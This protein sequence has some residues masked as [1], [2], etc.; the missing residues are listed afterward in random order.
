VSTHSC[1]LAPHLK[2][3]LAAIPDGKYGRMFI[4]LPI[5]VADEAA[6]LALGR[7]H[8]VIDSAIEPETGGG[9]SDN[10]R[11]PAGF[12]IFGQFVA[13]DITADRSLLQ[14]HA[15]LDEL[16]NFRAPRLDLESVYAA[17]PVGSPYLYDDNDPDK[18]LIGITDAGQPDDLPRNQQGIAL[19]GDPRNDVHLIIS[20]MHLAFLKFH[21]RI[22]DMLRSQGLDSAAVF[23]TARQLVRWHYQWIVIHEFLPLNVGAEVVGDILANGRQFYAYVERPFIPIEFA[24]AAYRFGHSQI[25]AIYRLNDHAEGRIFPD[26]VGRQPVPQDRAIDW[27]CIFS[28][29]PDRPPQLSKLIDGRMVH[30]LID[31]PDAIVGATAN[32]DERSLACR[33]LQRG[34]SLD[35]P[36]GEAVSRAMGIEP[37]T[38]AEC[39]LADPALLGETP[40]WL[41]ILKEA[42]VRK[43]GETL[44]NVGGRIVVEV[45]IGL[46]EGDADSYLNAA[47]AWRPTLPSA[48]PGNFTMADLLR[49]AGVA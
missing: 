8:A 47:I 14:H 39:G 44:G 33:D 13:H 12:P 46:I 2:D 36:S 40:L 32:R 22:V 48:Q 30:P 43:R 1:V 23:P 28:L 5:Y 27:R 35:L 24:D 29:D 41:Y 25:R 49:F 34:R 26:L 15:S 37:L 21:N 10:A 45:L 42:E 9:E 6:L 11:I 18:F 31:L 4:G 16:R 19:I 3:A 20:Q 38:S 17:G 7:A